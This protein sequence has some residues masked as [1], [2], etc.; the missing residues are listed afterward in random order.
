MP[1]S[2]CGQTDGYRPLAYLTDPWQAP[3][4][5]VKRQGVRML[6]KLSC[7]HTCL[8]IELCVLIFRV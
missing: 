4:L 6:D 5:G 8:A 7:S 1:L 2:A 3:M